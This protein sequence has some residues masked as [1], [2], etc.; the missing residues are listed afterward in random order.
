MKITTESG[1]KYLVNDMKLTRV[2]ER[3]PI[4]RSPEKARAPII[5]CPITFMSEPSIGYT[6]VVQ[7]HHN[8]LDMASSLRTNTITEIDYEEEK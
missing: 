5:G 6:W 8:E 3:P 1:T 7:F 2:S 4:S